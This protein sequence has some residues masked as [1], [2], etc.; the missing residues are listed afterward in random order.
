[1]APTVGPA[2]QETLYSG[3]IAEGQKV[4]Q[5]GKLIAD[6]I[7]NPRTVLMNSCTTALTVAYRLSGVERGTEVITTPL[8]CIASNEPIVS[9]GAK[10]IW[11]DVDPETGM[12]DPDDLEHLINEKTRAILV[13]HKEGDPA[14]LNEI[15]AVA[16]KHNL[17]VI[18]DAAHAIGT[19]YKGKRI[20]N[21]GDFI[22]FSFQAI[23]QLAT[24]D[25][26]ALLCKSED[27][28]NKARKMKWFGMDRENNSGKNIYLQDI[29]DYGFKGNMN[30]ITAAIGIEQMKHIDDI[31]KKH[32]RNG[33]LYS[34]LLTG[35]PGIKLIRREKDNYGAYW[36]YPLMAENRDGF[37]KKLKSEGIAS[38]QIH[39]RN[40]IYSIFKS[41]KR[42]LPHVDQFSKVDVSLPCGWWV[43]V[44]EVQRICDVIKK[45]W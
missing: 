33:E 7:G 37:E 2:V 28:F 44:K 38:G 10:P 19:E 9:L 11:V 4:I 16:K 45:G 40:D 3:Y 21:H 18:E 39:P 31:I 24:G 35:V 42:D 8:T 30:D 17:K 29:D 25:G 27:D 36:A 14:R 41:S 23:K 20:G 32:N 22:C 13:L 5:F 34:K 26:G 6:Y 1:M 43:E 12:V 15:M